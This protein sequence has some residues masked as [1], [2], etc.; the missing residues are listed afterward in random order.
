MNN[1]LVLQ[2]ENNFDAIATNGMENHSGSQTSKKF[3]V[4]KS[5]GTIL[6]SMTGNYFSCSAIIKN[7]FKL[8]AKRNY[9]SNDA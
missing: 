3:L 1:L 8:S 6:A 9:V 2:T 7:S 5:A 4:Q